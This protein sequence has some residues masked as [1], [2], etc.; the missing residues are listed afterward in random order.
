MAVTW[1]NGS[2]SANTISLGYTEVEVNL[3]SLA[4]FSGSF[5]ITGTGL[6]IGRVVHIRQSA[7]PYTGKGTRA[8]ESEM[9]YVN[10][11][12]KVINSTTIQ[13]FWKCDTRVKGNR[14]F[15]YAV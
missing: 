11:T 4:K 7:A 2:T 1:V 8:D 14:K 6:E 5:S 3:G 15:F 10:V 12:A 13:C 9:D